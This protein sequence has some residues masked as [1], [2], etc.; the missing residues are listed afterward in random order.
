M[1][2]FAIEVQ[3]SYNNGRAQFLRGLLPRAI[4][5]PIVLAPTLLLVKSLQL[6]WSAD[7]C[8]LNLRVS[9]LRISWNNLT[10]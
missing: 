6:I 2:V 9:D 1:E 3:Y 7:S 4:V 5:E 10:K 8:R